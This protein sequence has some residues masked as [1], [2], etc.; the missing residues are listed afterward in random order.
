MALAFRWYLGYTS[1]WANG[2]EASRHL[3]YQIW[4]GPAMGAFNEWVRDSFL[5]P[6]AN[7]SVI[8]VAMNILFGAA[9]LYRTGLL[10]HHGVPLPQ[11]GQQVEP[12]A[13]RDL[14]A[15]LH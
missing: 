13:V 1:T 2:G 11:A 4:C 12:M 8:A 6:P 9:V 7:R 15:F 10:R 3:D 14:E 5:E